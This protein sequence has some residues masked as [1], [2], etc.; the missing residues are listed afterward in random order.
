MEQQF[1]RFVVGGFTVVAGYG[2]VDVGRDKPSLDSFQPCQ[3]VLRHHDGIGAGAFG[4]GDADRR[5]AVPIAA[6][7][8]RFH[9]DPVFLRARADHDGRYVTHIDRTVVAR[10]DEQKPDIGNAG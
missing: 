9:P 8:R 6:F 1:V 10:G 5:H 4:K 2:D 7:S 3:Q